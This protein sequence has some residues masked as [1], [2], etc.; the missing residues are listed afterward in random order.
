MDKNSEILYNIYNREGNDIKMK[1]NI[2]III[3]I[4]IF[5]ACLL[6]VNKVEAAIITSDHYLISEGTDNNLYIKGILTDTTINDIIGDIQHSSDNIQAFN[7]DGSGARKESIAKTGMKLKID[8]TNY[9][10]VVCGDVNGDGKITQTDLIKMKFQ[11]VKKEEQKGAYLE[12]CDIDS[13][14]KL[15]STDLLKI[16]RVLTKII[17]QEEIYLTSSQTKDF[18]YTINNL[19]KAV[20]I[21]EYIGTNA[22]VIIPNRI[23]E[24]EVNKIDFIGNDIIT[25]ISVPIN[26]ENIAANSWKECSN[27]TTITVNPSNANYRSIDGILYSKDETKLIRYP[28]AKE[29]ETYQIDEDVRTIAEGAFYKTKNLKELIIPKTVQTIETNSFYKWDGYIIGKNNTVGID[30]AKSNGV[31]YKIDMPPEIT[32]AESNKELMQTSEIQIIASDDYG[33]TGWQVTSTNEEPTRWTLVNN[34]RTLEVTKDRITE[35]GT[36][37]VWVRDTQNDTSMKE[38]KVE[39]VDR[40][41]LVVQSIG[42]ISPASGTYSS[43]QR[44]VIRVVF[45]KNI[46]GTPPTLKLRI[47]NKIGTG[48]MSSTS[49]DASTNYI[50]YTYFSGDESGLVE[51]DSLTGGDIRD[52]AGNSAIITTKNNTGNKIVLADEILEI[53][54][55][56]VPRRYYSNGEIRDFQGDSIIITSGGETMLLDGGYETYNGSSGTA[57]D[58]ANYLEEKGIKKLKYVIASHEHND[59]VGGL[60]EFLDEY[61]NIEVE[62]FYSSPYFRADSSATF[63]I[64]SILNERG[65]TRKTLRVG[66]ILTL[67]S[68]AIECLGPLTE[69][70][71]QSSEEEN[72][73]SLIL[74]ISLGNTSYLTCGDADNANTNAELAKRWGDNLKCTVLHLAHHGGGP[75]NA[76]F[77]EAANPTIQVASSGWLESS[78]SVYST[79]NGE[80][81]IYLDGETVRVER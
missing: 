39:N 48:T 51:I 46:T 12:A 65:I 49:P 41:E 56:N 74:K 4:V 69:H 14:G 16:K 76:A 64:G 53:H 25:S 19:T 23:G 42:I 5:L 36:Y 1:K 34:L 79:L 59:H 47:G 66:D 78:P 15:G 63:N 75:N 31:L 68:T 73:N 33:I 77:M 80:F 17:T 44:I 70:S 11:L 13:N 32:K 43:G 27:L 28:Q 61:R 2:K 29:D 6:C 3:Q 35:N 52:L 72:Q 20:T 37:Y 40:E 57:K 9:Y 26:V 62:E 45:N 30:F 18:K 54:Y 7:A 10:L 81:T 58:I 71:H 24:Y 38:V 22:D 50:D 67:G 60:A 55:I 21:T 8:E